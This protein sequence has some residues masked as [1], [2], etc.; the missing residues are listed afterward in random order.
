MSKLLR[1]PGFDLELLE[2]DSINRNFTSVERDCKR[3]MWKSR[4]VALLR[5]VG[6]LSQVWPTGT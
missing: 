6:D 1:I 2:W 3:R 5:D 4:D